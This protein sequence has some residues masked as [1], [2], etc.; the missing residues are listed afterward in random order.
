MQCLLTLRGKR[1]SVRPHL[2][3]SATLTLVFLLSTNAGLLGA[4]TSDQLSAHCICEPPGP[5]GLCLHDPDS[6]LGTNWG[7]KIVIS[8]FCSLPLLLSRFLFLF[9]LLVT[10][11]LAGCFLFCFVCCC[12]VL[13]FFCCFFINN[14]FYMCVCVCVFAF[15]SLVIIIISLLRFS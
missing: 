8:G 6:A 4:R 10:V 9:S 11:S 1:E 13:L 15:F 3:L 2:N 12:F 7:A 14:F 5:C